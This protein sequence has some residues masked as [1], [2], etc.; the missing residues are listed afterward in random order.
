MT[1]IR[2]YTG[3]HYQLYFFLSRNTLIVWKSHKWE[4][5]QVDRRKGKCAASAGRLCVF[6]ADLTSAT[7]IWVITFLRSFA[8]Q[9]TQWILNFV[10]FCVTSISTYRS[11]SH[12]AELFMFTECKGKEEAGISVRH[13]ENILS[14]YLYPLI[15]VNYTRRDWSPSNSMHILK[16]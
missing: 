7:Y 6:R 5:V 12:Y 2:R 4:D 1:C 15:V 11:R 10:M 9:E 8:I 3:D 16:S 14:S 13:L